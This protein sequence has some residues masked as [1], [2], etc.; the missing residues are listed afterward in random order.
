MEA[1]QFLR[2]IDSRDSARQW[3]RR[4]QR[5]S[6]LLDQP[7]H[8]VSAWKFLN[9][10]AKIIVGRLLTRHERGQHRQAAEQIETIGW[11]QES[12]RQRKIE[13]EQVSAR[14]QNAT[15]FTQSKAPIRHIAQP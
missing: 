9:R 1:S 11:S 13:N 2:G 5:K 8:L 3:I 7:N 4:R 12:N 14:A 15:H 6:V 10:A